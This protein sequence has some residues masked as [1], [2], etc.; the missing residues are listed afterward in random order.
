MAAAITAMADKP[1]TQIT[2]QPAAAPDVKVD[3]HI[4]KKG[5]RTGK[6]TGSDGTEY[7]M[8]TEEK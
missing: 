1:P 7:T 4:P 8:E 6:M 2:V 5:R 3:V